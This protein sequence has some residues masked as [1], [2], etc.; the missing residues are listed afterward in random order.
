M[1][2]SYSDGST[3]GLRRKFGVMGHTAPKNHPA[4]YISP[5]ARGAS[6]YVTGDHPLAG[7][8]IRVP[9][10]RPSSHFINWSDRD[11]NAGRGGYTPDNPGWYLAG[12]AGQETRADALQANGLL[13]GAG[14]ALGAVKQERRLDTQSKLEQH[15]ENLQHYDPG[16]LQAELAELKARFPDRPGMDVKDPKEDAPNIVIRNEEGRILMQGKAES[17]EHLIALKMKEASTSTDPSKQTVNLA[18][19]QLDEKTI[20][21][22]LDFRGM[23]FQNMDLRGANLGGA[24]FQDCQFKNV[25]MEGAGL[26][27]CTFNLCHF[28]NVNMSGFVGDKNTRFS[29]SS[30]YNVD[31]SYADAPQIKFENIRGEYLNMQGA[32]FAG[33]HI[34]KMEV[35]NLWA[36]QVNLEG[37]S[38]GGLKISGQYSSLEG[39]K[40]NGAEIGQ[41]VFGTREHPLNMKDVQAQNSTWTDCVLNADLSRADFTGASFTRVDMRNSS[42]PGGPMIVQN[43]NMTGLEAGPAVKMAASRLVYDNVTMQVENNSE[44]VF[45]GTAQLRNA[46]RKAVDSGLNYIQ[47]RGNGAGLDAIDPDTQRVLGEQAPAMAVRKPAMMPGLEPPSPFKKKGAQGW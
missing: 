41:S 20:G 19:A 24:Q 27:G 39:A 3:S 1:A 34:N 31:M 28:E 22:K 11:G 47:L 30:M 37:A 9:S 35:E 6:P 4:V 15:F 2:F 7:G 46:H 29:N 38:I 26:K 12:L 8:D 5:Y 18:G 32:N 16:R 36:P 17:V 14:Y 45:E 10:D 23:N 42:T 13:G 44:M 21:R 33:A 43:A 25:D 40:L